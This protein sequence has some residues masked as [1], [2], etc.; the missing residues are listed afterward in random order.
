MSEPSSS[1]DRG[2]NWENTEGKVTVAKRKKGKCQVMVPSSKDG[3][4]KK[5]N[6]D[7][8]ILPYSYMNTKGGLLCIQLGVIYCTPCNSKHGNVHSID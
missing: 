5:K 6:P 3:L 4:K 2:L 8:T 7:K 1:R